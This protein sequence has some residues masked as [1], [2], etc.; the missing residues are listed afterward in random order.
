MG[1]FKPTR[2]PLECD[3]LPEVPCKECG[4]VGET[5][6]VCRECDRTVCMACF[7]QEEWVPIDHG[8]EDLC[9]ECNGTTPIDFE[10]Y[11]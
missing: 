7:D 11:R 3:E 4:T 2:D 6:R 10:P 5:D 1:E 9:H 8:D